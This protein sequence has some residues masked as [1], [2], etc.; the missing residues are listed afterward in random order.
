M[1]ID[2]SDDIDIYQML[3]ILFRNMVPIVSITSFFAIVSVIYALSLPN[4]YRSSALLYPSESDDSA[5]NQLTQRYGS[6]ASLA[7]VSLPPTE[8]GTKANIA[9]NKLYSREFLQHLLTFEGVTQKLYATKIFNSDNGEI[10]FDPEIFN[11]EKK[12]WVRKVEYP[13]SPEP[14]LLEVHDLY[15][16][17]ILTVYH[18]KLTNFITISVSHKSPIFAKEFLDLVIKELNNI[19]RDESIGQSNQALMYL[20][21]KY[22]S[23]FDIQ[24]KESVSRIIESQM[25]IQM[26]ANIRDDYLLQIIDKPFI[27]EK[28]IS[29]T[30]SIICILVTFIGFI[31]SIVFVFA[32]EYIIRK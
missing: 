1:N 19:S 20:N 13:F 30:R 3:K 24:I 22:S 4:I 21:D 28:K 16:S 32:K 11:F 9:I 15:L 7:G 23:A 17:E 26:F 14:S 12:A 31:I 6:L 29:P 10:I 27:P 18:D 2:R 5:M 8:T 25:Q